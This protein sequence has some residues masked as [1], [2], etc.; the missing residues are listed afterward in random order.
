VK[1]ELTVNVRLRKVRC[2]PTGKKCSVC[3]DMALLREYRYRLQI[4]GKDSGYMRI[5]GRVLRLCGSCSDVLDDQ[6]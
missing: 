2:K 1:S 3:G 6:G 4:N 5:D